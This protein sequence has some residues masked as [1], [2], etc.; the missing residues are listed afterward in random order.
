MF[1]GNA[2]GDLLPPYVVYKAEALWNTW[3]E[4]GP[5]QARYNRSWSGWFDHQC[6]EDWFLTLLLPRLRSDGL[7]HVLIGDNLSSHMN[8]AVL[9]AC[10]QNNVSF[11]ALPPNSTHLTQPLDVAFSD[12]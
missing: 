10:K 4:H 8:V 1:C 11:V 5:P 2:E 12:L 9:E 7:R 6:F 3:M